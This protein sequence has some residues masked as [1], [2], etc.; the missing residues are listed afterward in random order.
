MTTK[1]LL[2]AAGLTISIPAIAQTLPA[3]DTAVSSVPAQPQKV[4]EGATPGAVATI[5]RCSGHKF[6]SL[7]EIDPVKK[8]STRVKLCA[9]PGASD[10][11]WVKTL[12]AAIAQIEQRPMPAAAKAKLIGELE[13]EV[14]KFSSS[15]SASASTGIFLG[16][17][18]GAKDSLI[19]PAERFETSTL[20][21]LT[22][23]KVVKAGASVEARPQ[24]PM[25]IRL[26]CLS[27]GESGS[28]QTCDF[29]DR[30]TVLVVSAVRGLE[31]GGSLRFRRKGEERGAADLGP[32]RAGQTARVKLPGELCRGIS[33]S[34]VEIELLGPDSNGTAAARL[35]P[36]GLRC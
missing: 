5:E 23:K 21:P 11:E 24:R 19:Q 25:G 22:P 16:T 31:N 32:M 36:Y 17:N 4:V 33:H 13:G 12:E 2:L 27:S 34:K 28:G 1:W 18:I 29:F 26:K 15:K 7:V 8:R 14:A 6:E 9:N 3:P 35:G 20:P 30:G 10:A